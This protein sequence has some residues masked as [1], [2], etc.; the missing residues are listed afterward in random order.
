MS[1]SA[2]YD[3]LKMCKE[4]GL[5]SSATSL[6]Y[7]AR[8]FQMTISPFKQFCFRDMQPSVSETS[9][10]YYVPWHN[11]Q[12]L[13]RIHNN[14]TDY[15]TAL[16][17][18]NAITEYAASI[19]NYTMTDGDKYLS[20]IVTRAATPLGETSFEGKQGYLFS[21]DI[22]LTKDITNDA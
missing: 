4:A 12:I 15:L 22:R 21:C 13:L 9:D 14:G 7:S 10:S 11:V 3:F 19:R 2:A 16:S 17:K 20:A 8:V 1:E 5:V 18:L 6:D